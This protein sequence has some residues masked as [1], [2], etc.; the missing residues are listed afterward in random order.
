MHL[1]ENRYAQLVT[2]YRVAFIL[3][4]LVLVALCASGMSKLYFTSNYRVFFSSDN[5]QLNAFETLENTYARE[6]NVMFIIAPRDGQVFTR[7]TLAAVEDLSERAWQL[8]YSTRVDSIAEFQH[9]EAEGDE[10]VVRNLVEHAHALSDAEIDHI[11]NV[12]LTEPNLVNS[13]VSPEAHVTAINVTIQYP[14]IDETREVPE[15]VSAVRTLAGEIRE[16]YPDIALYTTGIVMLNNAFVESSQRDM[17]TLVPISFAIMMVALALL[18]RGFSGTVTTLLVII[19]SIVSA[20]GLGGHLGIPIT[21]PTSSAPII[22]LTLALASSVHILV[23]FY[24]ELS[25]G[26]QRRKAVAE[27]IRVNLQPVF[28]ASITTALGF[29]SMIFN[30]APPF[31]HLGILVAM[32]VIASFVYAVTFLPAMISLL[33]ARQPKRVRYDSHMMSTI[34]EFVIRQRRRLLWSGGAGILALVS[35]A[36]LNELNDVFPH[37]FDESMEFRQHSDFANDNLGGM[38]RF[39]YSIAS[40]ESQGVNDPAFLAAVERFADWWREQPETIHVNSITDT[41]RRLNK[42]MHGDD[43]A[44]YRLPEKRDLAA[45]YLLLYEMSLPYGLDLNNQINVDKSATRMSVTTQIISTKEVLALEQRASDW[46]RAQAP[47]LGNPQGSSSTIM[48]AHIGARNVKSMLVGASAALVLI[49]L[50][51]IVALRSVRI[52]LVS[53]IP[54]LAPAAMGFGIWGLTVGEIGLGLSIVMGMTLGI[55][56]DDSVHFLSK[57]LRARRERGL[58]SADSVRY[59]FTHVGTA[60]WITSL[61]LVAGFLVLAQSS[62]QLNS[63]MGTLTAVVIALAL[64]ADFLFLPPLLMKLE[65]KQHGENSDAVSVSTVES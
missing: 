4:T 14:R 57:Y 8:P 40:R 19:F 26:V 30:D 50:T 21:P 25:E 28:L 51:L 17:K 7:Q 1:L 31:R 16:Q 59:A 49:S 44:W 52:G 56:V 35:M 39:D 37:Y 45:Q 41:M 9:T 36:P 42:N 5:P 64:V 48:F 34:A 22:I 33:P 55:V 29:L 2:R 20:M 11:R 60:L 63:D 15:V 54:N 32:G 62:F 18:L 58:G 13:L 43:P 47:E 6:D 65:E 3:L 46:L 10:L 27:A 61:V 53:M 38:Y 12:A 24:H 23:S